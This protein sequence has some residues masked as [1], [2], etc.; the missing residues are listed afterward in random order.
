[1]TGGD[2][3]LTLIPIRTGDRDGVPGNRLRAVLM[4]RAV[5]TPTKAVVIA[6]DCRGK[7]RP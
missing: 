6:G 4:G 7:P 3:G 5:L 2:L 1:M